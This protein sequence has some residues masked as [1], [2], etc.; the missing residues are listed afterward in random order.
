MRINKDNSVDVQIPEGV[1]VRFEKPKLIVS[2]PNGEVSRLIRSPMITVSVEKGNVKLKAS[3]LTKREKKLLGTFVAHINNM[4]KGV[5]EGFVYKLKV[6]SGH[7]PMNV[8]V[9]GEEFTVNNFIGEK[10]PRRLRIKH[11]GVKVEVDGDIIT[12]SG[13]DKEQ[14]AQ[15]AGDI[16]GLLKRA[17]YDKRI[18][19]DGIYIIEKDGKHT[20]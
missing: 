19:Q 5:T 15:T 10:F 1:E 9:K 6:C 17:N 8:Q 16:E 4:I 13:I 14:V 12:V 2:G 18:F 3:V 20:K 7:F 11:Q